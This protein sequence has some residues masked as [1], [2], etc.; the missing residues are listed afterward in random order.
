[1]ALRT[2]TEAR[3]AE[4]AKPREFGYEE[5]VAMHGRG[6]A[7]TWNY[8]GVGLWRSLLSDEYLAQASDRELHAIAWGASVPTALASVW[9]G[10]YAGLGA[11]GSMVVGGATEGAVLYGSA[12]VIANGIELFEGDGNYTHSGASVEG[13]AYQVGSGAVFG[14]T[15]WGVGVIA[16]PGI[17]M[18]SPYLQNVK[19][20]ARAMVYGD[21]FAK[22][23]IP[24]KTLTWV[25]D[26]PR[27]RGITDEFG[28]MEVSSIGN[29]RH[30]VQGLAHEMV[31]S[32]LSPTK[33]RWGLGSREVRA[34]RAEW[35]YQN[36]TL[37]QYTEELAAEF[38]S[39]LVT[40]TLRKQP[41]SVGRLFQLS[42]QITVKYNEI[43]VARLR[44]EAVVGGTTIS[45]LWYTSYVLGRYLAGE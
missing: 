20:I 3:A 21:G 30:Q 32:A 29:L 6:I 37:M 18:I 31:H 11:L 40:N 28:H 15:A 25:D 10:S 41:K 36:S 19:A 42:H 7:G 27:G 13:F 8:M 5:R 1:M 35:W 39:Q 12:H 23:P 38:T 26:I 4:I 33:G 9:V 43:N 44:T 2:E 16:R 17:R 14:G 24:G 22:N 34:S 45:G